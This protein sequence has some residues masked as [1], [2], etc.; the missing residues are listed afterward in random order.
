MQLQCHIL[1]LRWNTETRV[2]SLKN[3]KKGPF[4]CRALYLI[5]EILASQITAIYSSFPV[6]HISCNLFSI[7]DMIFQSAFIFF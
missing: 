1:P 5:N 6:K 2:K 3:F 7:F 4:V